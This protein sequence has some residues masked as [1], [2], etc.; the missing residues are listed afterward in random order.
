MSKIQFYSVYHLN[1]AFSSIDQIRHSDVVSS[2]YWPLLQLA[3]KFPIAIELTVYTL[4]CVELVDPDWIKQLASLIRQGKVELI[5]SGDSQIIAPLVPAEVTRRNLNMGQQ[6]YRAFL[7]CSPRIAFVNEQAYSRGMLDLYAEAG[8][9][10]IIM[11][12][13]NPFN[14]HE[15]WQKDWCYYPQHASGLR[16][17]LP[18]LWN[19]S[20]A[21]QKFQRYAHGELILDDYLDYL[22]SHIDADQRRAF[23]MYGNDAEVFDFR[24]GRFDTEVLIKH[25]EWQRIGKLYHAVSE[26]PDIELVLPSRVLELWN[27]SSLA[28]NV[29]DLAS[30][31]MPVPVK[32]T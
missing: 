18:V 30:D 13:N 6:S 9:K 19:K 29:L 28:G 11:E 25:H 5:A 32:T 31:E 17:S 21:F 22:F 24:P 12:W 14:H 15:D 23:P 20:I 16:R 8:F 2:C 10:A 4:E 26:N 7:G 27:D 3:E 1:L